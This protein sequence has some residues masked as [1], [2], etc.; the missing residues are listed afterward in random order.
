MCYLYVDHRCHIHYGDINYYFNHNHVNIDYNRY[1]YNN[2][3]NHVCGYY[4]INLFNIYGRAYDNNPTQHYRSRI[5]YYKQGIGHDEKLRR[6]RG[7][8]RAYAKYSSSACHIN[9]PL[10]GYCYNRSRRVCAFN[11]LCIHNPFRA[12]RA[13]FNEHLPAR[14]HIRIYDSASCLPY[15]GRHHAEAGGE[16]IQ[17]S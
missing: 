9:Y 13:R 15:C 10:Q 2:Y 6:R 12:G 11:P 5:Y 14:E 17:R 4:I 8:W 16:G 7:Q 1:N 3:Y